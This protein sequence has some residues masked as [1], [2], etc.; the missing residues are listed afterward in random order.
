MCD[1]VVPEYIKRLSPYVPGKPV[2]QLERELGI[3]GAIKLASNE[4][5]LGPSPRA[6]EAIRA[7]AEHVHFYPEGAAPVLRDAVAKHLDVDPIHL[8]FGNGSDEILLLLTLS[9]I[10]G[11]SDE[12]V[13]G[14]PSFAMYEIYATLANAKLT[15]VPLNNYAHDLPAMAD[16]VTERTRLVFIANP[17]NPTGTLVSAK[18][19]A[20]L[21]ERMPPTATVVFD[22]AYHEFVD[23]ADR[24]ETIRYVLEGRNVVVT[25]T[26]SKAYAL[27]GLRVGYAIA[28]RALAGYMD[29]VRSPFNVNLVAQS[30]AAAALSDSD[31]LRKSIEVNTAGRKQLVAGFDKLKLNW[32]PS[33]GNFVL[34]DVSDANGRDGLTVYN[35]L[36]RKGVIVRPTAGF[37]LPKHIRVSIGTREQNDR[38]L[39]ALAEVL[40]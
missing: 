34:V 30:A 20:A 4:N 3:Q 40:A 36:L 9:L 25:R 16:K 1:I 10:S 14:D 13:I 35:A 8:V 11:P 7:A 26:F 22:E 32:V 15:K 23:P 27:A 24:A 31:H 39:N 33:S 5:P 19:I 18:E 28:P 37:G 17:N 29:R 2:E 38:F 12:I 21:L 6:I